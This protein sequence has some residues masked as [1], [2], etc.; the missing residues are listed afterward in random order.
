MDYLQTRQD[1][2]DTERR[3]NLAMAENEALRVWIL[4]LEEEKA[5]LRALLQGHKERSPCRQSHEPEPREQ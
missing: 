1:V 3:V 5:S 2:G 4:Q